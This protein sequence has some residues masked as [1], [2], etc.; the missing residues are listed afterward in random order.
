[1]SIFLPVAGVSL[2]LLYLIGIGTSES[3][4]SGLVGVGGGFLLTPALMMMGVTATV[5]A[6]SGFCQ[7]VATSF[8]GVAAHFHLGN[9]NIKIGAALPFCGHPERPL[10]LRLW[11]S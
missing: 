7:M 9:V 1:M 4:L 3:S 5:A 11:Q 8:S 2:S 6:E 10:L